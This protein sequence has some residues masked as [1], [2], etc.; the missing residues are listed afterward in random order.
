M[1]SRNLCGYRLRPIYYHLELYMAPNTD[2]ERTFMGHVRKVSLV[3]NKNKLK[4]SCDVSIGVNGPNI[5]Q[6]V[7]DISDT[8][9]VHCLLIALQV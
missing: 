3:S 9:S 1:P 6:K 2:Y 5:C 8:I 7:F 4:V